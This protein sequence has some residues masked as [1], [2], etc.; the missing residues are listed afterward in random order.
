[1]REVAFEAIHIDEMPE[2]KYEKKPDDTDWRPIRIH[3]GIS[4]FG[5]NGFTAQKGQT[6][7][8]EHRE[9]D[10]SG[11]RHE[12]LYFVSRGN[13]SFTVEGEKIAAPAGTFV[14]VPDPAA[15]RSAVALEDD[16]TVLCFGGTQGEAFGVSE[17]ERKYDPAEAR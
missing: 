5:A 1:M 16:T 13:A 17:W 9:T 6:V 4:S 3:F 14:Y 7:V 15:M 11:T 10:E 2:P 12:E 8:G